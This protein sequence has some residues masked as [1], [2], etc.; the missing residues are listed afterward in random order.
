MT[1]TQQQLYS[2][3]GTSKPQ[4]PRLLPRRPRPAEIFST[5]WA[6]YKVPHALLEELGA[7]VSQAVARIVDEALRQKA[8]PQGYYVLRALDNENW[9]R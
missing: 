7:S 3:N 8:L 4:G 6:E 9:L 2:D 5:L 1:L